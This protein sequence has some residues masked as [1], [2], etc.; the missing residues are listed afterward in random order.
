MRVEQP[1][2]LRN[3]SEE[4]KVEAELAGSDPAVRRGRAAPRAA[5]AVDAGG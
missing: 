3:T 1:R 4:E 5:A 2:C